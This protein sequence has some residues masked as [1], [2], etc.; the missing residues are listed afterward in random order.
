MEIILTPEQAARLA[1]LATRQGRRTNDLVQEAL[2]RYLEDDSRFVD[3]VIKGLASLDRG[4][5]LTHAEV[6]RRVDRLLES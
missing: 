4:E 1:E 3:A 2:A 6:G 5:F